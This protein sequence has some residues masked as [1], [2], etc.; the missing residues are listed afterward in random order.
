MCCPVCVAVQIVSPEVQSRL[1]HMVLDGMQEL[2]R[3]L[4]AGWPCSRRRLL[5]PALALPPS[6]LLPLG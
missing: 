6:P 2:V 4:A 3:R 1:L 5:A